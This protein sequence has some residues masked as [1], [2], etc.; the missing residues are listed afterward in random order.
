MYSSEEIR[1]NNKFKG[2]VN[3][4]SK[5]PRPSLTTII[6]VLEKWDELYRLA[7]NNVRKDF[8]NKE[9]LRNCITFIDYVEEHILFLL[10]WCAEYMADLPFQDKLRGWLTYGIKNTTETRTP[11]NFEK[12]WK[13]FFRKNGD[14]PDIITLDSSDFDVSYRNYLK[15]MDDMKQEKEFSNCT[16]LDILDNHKDIICDDGIY[17]S[18]CEDQEERWHVFVSNKYKSMNNIF[19]NR[20]LGKVFIEKWLDAVLQLSDTEQEKINFTWP[21]V[22]SYSINKFLHD[23]KQ[24]DYNEYLS[25]LIKERDKRYYG[26]SFRPKVEFE[27]INDLKLSLHDY[28]IAQIYPL[29]ETKN[30]YNEI[31]LVL[32]HILSYV[33][34]ALYIDRKRCNELIDIFDKL[35]DE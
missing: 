9:F 31:Y 7:D 10:K 34:Y 25:E 3:G 22:R 35:P 11:I 29:K 20:T 18:L 1:N 23:G 13:L 21:P 16:I 32:S 17:C 14:Q 4:A 15:L 5:I 26:Y 12:Y 8:G 6:P 2:R 27:F 33:S 28:S 19:I 30:Q 24:Y